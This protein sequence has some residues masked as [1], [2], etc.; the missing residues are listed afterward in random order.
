MMAK[1]STYDA[2]EIEVLEGLEPVRVRPAMYI[3]GTDTTG[4]H[5]LVW[6]IVDNSVDEVM[7]GFASK[8][9]VTL[10]KG[11]TKVTVDDDGRGIPIDLMSKYKKPALEVILTT[12]HSGGKF[13]KTS[14]THSGGLH[15]VGSSVVNALSTLLVAEVKRDG[16]RYEQ[17]F[18]KGKTKTKLKVLGPARGT[19]ERVIEPELIVP[20]LE[21]ETR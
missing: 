21:G 4:Y 8:I 3:G 10:H 11:G 7:N 18:A 14:Y 6:E 5:H 9:E 15:G 17:Q 1:K 16:K 12:L 13:Q 2:S 19:L 20:Q